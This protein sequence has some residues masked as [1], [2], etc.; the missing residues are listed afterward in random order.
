[1]AIA[2]MTKVMVVAHHSQAAQLLEALQAEGILQV[3]DASEAAVGR[4]WPELQQEPQRPRELQELVNRLG[5]SV[6]LLKEHS[7]EKK[8]LTDI[9]APR[10]VIGEKQYSEAVSGRDALGVLQQ[11]EQ[12]EAKIAHLKTEYENHLGMLDILRPWQGLATPVEQ[13]GKLD[14][15]VCLTGLIPVAHFEQ[16]VEKLA[17]LFAAVQQVGQV[18]NL[19]ACVIVALNESLT[20]VHKT[21]RAADFEPVDFEGMKGTV[22]Q[23]IKLHS[24]KLGEI[25][26]Q[27]SD[28]YEKAAALS[29]ERLKLQILFDHYEKLLTREQVRTN[30]PAT[31]HAVF[32][33]GWVRKRDLP[34]LEKLVARFPA[35]SLTKIEP[36]E[37]E[38]S[39]PLWRRCGGK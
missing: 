7:K 9:L 23:L 2:E 17:E 30:V 4:Q 26:K 14:R 28:E 32:L 36:A 38:H 22:A 24:E 33:E 31:E 12:T 6:T 20:D 21:L 18:N 19:R 34:L 3:L 15:T 11:C 5:K 37:N 39:C 10:A 27:L 35:S 29:R 8:T 16:T 25:S 1:M 13:I